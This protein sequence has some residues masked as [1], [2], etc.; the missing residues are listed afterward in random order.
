MHENH[1][2][3]KKMDYITEYRKGLKDKIAD[4]AMKEFYTRGI[5]AVKMD[6]ISQGLHVSKRTVYEIFGDKE[7]LLLFGL[8]VE[9]ERM[10]R[11]VEDFVAHNNHNV[12]DIFAFY[13]RMQ[14]ERNQQVDPIFLEDIN[15]Y[16]RVVT[17]LRGTADR[18][19]E[20]RLDFYKRGIQEGLFRADVDYV[21]L[22]KVG[23]IAVEGIMQRQLYKEYPIQT[24]FDNYFL[25]MMRGFCTERG[26]N[27]LAKA[28]DIYNIA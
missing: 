23:Q 8:Q 4:H 24:L 22:T 1:I 15:K 2:Q 10:M 11:K 12:I 3:L 7:E 25:L 5:K 6:E 17:Y 18:E 9:R 19:R 16:T 13:Y 21:L 14:M 26:L 27:M 20:Q 28:L